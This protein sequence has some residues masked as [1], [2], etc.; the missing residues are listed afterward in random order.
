MAQ[1]A[2]GSG[3]MAMRKGAEDLKGLLAGDEILSLQ[4]AAQ[5]IDLR[6]GPRGEIGE[7]AFVDFGA[8]TDRFAKEDGRGRVAVGDGFDVHGSIIHVY[9]C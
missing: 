2:E 7:G 1:G 9:K 8:G 6:G 3:D 5:E 4:E